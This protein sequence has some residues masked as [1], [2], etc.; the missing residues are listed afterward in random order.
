MLKGCSR[1]SIGAGHQRSHQQKSLDQVSEGNT[2]K[3]T[4]QDRREEELENNVIAQTEV[5]L[6]ELK[7]V[8][9]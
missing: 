8:F 9:A 2:E 7:A 5:R 4:S 3:E 1:V 6:I